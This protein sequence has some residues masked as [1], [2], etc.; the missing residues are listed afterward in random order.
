MQYQPAMLQ[1]QIEEWFRSNG[2]SSTLSNAVHRCEDEYLE[3]SSSVRLNEGKERIAE[4]AADLCMCL[5]MVANIAG[6]DLLV[7]VGAKLEI[8]RQRQW[9][10]DEFGCLHHIKG[11]DPRASL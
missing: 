8:N 9:R 11:T 1:I 4:E 7:A 2:G 5:M 6:F 3:L 10:V